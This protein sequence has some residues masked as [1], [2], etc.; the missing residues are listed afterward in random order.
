MGKEARLGEEGE[1]EEEM[2]DFPV[3][4]EHTEGVVKSGDSAPWPHIS[5]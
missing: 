3:T 4:L 2:R 1:E 5:S